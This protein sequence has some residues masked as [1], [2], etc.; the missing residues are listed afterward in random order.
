[1]NT[2]VKNPVIGIVGGRGTLGQLFKRA[3][4]TAGY[5]VLTSGRKP[6]GTKVLSNAQLV[7]KADVVVV[8]VFLKDTEQVL[9]EIAPLLNSKQLLCDFASVKVR[10]VQIMLTS[11]AEVVGLHPMFGTVANLAGQNIFACPVRSKKWW[12]WLRE[13]LTSFG[14]SVHETSPEQHDELAV[15]HQSVPHLLS[16][17]LATFLARRGVNPADIFA[18]SSPSTRLAL[19]TAGR[20]LTQD[21]EL[22]RDL[23]FQNP[24][25]KKSSAELRHIVL[26]LGKL[27]EKRRGKQFLAELEHAA[28]HFGDWKEFA[29]A[30]TNKLFVQPAT[31]K[32]KL[33]TGNSQLGTGNS[34]A[35]LGPA[36]QTELAAVEFVDKTKAK[37]TPVFF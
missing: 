34:I 13:I 27:V 33:A 21:H 17:A 1:M 24:T 7:K 8:S 15:V 36:T 6:S 28:Q 10:P 12:S 32:P 5:K 23:Q 14:L 3:F 4:E 22:Y 29:L 31:P 9:K 2:P 25:T 16:I 35:V 37:L 20:L 26:H 30:E 11:K 19:L 18:T